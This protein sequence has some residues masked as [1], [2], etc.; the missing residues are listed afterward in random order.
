MKAYLL[1]AFCIAFATAQVVDLTPDNFDSFV[2]KDKGAFVEFFAPWCGHCKNLA[3]AYEVVGESF[4][5]SKDV[6]IAKVDADAHNELGGRFGVSGFPT[7]KWFPKG[8]STPE[9]YNGGRSA[10]DIINFI[11]GKA[12]TNVRV[13]KAPSNVVDLD[14]KNFNSIALNTQKDVLAE[15]YAP[16]CGHCKHL[17]PD[18]EKVA[19]AF[20]GEKNV[21]VA[22]LDADNY[23]DLAGKYGVSG[24]PTLLWFG[25]D[26]KENPERYDKARDVQ[27]FVDYI[28]SKAGTH[29]LASGRLE[30][31]AGRISSLDSIAVKFISGDKAALTKEATTEAGKLTGDDEKNGKYYVKVM[32]T[33]QSKG[34]EFVDNEIARL[35]KLMEGSVAPAKVDEFTVKQN[36]LRAFK[37]YV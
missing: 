9:D 8:S 5:K 7:L 37:N 23:K 1:A 6:V 20:A 27:S 31:D 10:D 32:E 30:E 16:W 19:A 29:R 2:G 14:D 13:K 17:A 12:G 24:F 22:K 3:P 28:N 4:G 11:N 26:N 21:V 25:K 36:I 33:I 15:F 34:A 18:Y 35:N